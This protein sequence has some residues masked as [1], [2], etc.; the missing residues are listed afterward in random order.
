MV[1][2][3]RVL[4]EKQ[5]QDTTFYCVDESG[6]SGSSASNATFVSEPICNES[7]RG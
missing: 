5:Q 2:D 1:E 4:E 7:S 3:A 6:V